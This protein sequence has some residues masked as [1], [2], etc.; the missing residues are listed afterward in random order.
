MGW[1][2]RRRLQHLREVKK[3]IWH[4]D[5][6]M[7]LRTLA[8]RRMRQSRG[9]TVRCGIEFKTMSSCVFWNR[10]NRLAFRLL[11]PPKRW[12]CDVGDDWEG[13]AGDGGGE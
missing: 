10:N 11:R 8:R 13:Y 6:M 7:I 5:M 4:W 2:W 3:V 12:R 1:R 9:R